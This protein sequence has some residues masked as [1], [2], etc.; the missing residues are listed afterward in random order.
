M[1]KGKSTKPPKSKDDWQTPFSLFNHLNEIY[2]FNFDAAATEENTKCV[3]F[4]GD[5]LNEPWGDTTWLNPP[6]SKKSEFIEKAF[7]ERDNGNT[8]VMLLPASTGSKWFRKMSCMADEILFIVGRLTF[9]GAPTS[10]DFD[11]C[12]AVFRP[13]MPTVCRMSF[14]DLPPELRK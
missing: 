8:T 11:C 4:S 3:E 10:A 2:H 14:L 9:V 1:A 13:S 7:E 6:F 5:S 12:I